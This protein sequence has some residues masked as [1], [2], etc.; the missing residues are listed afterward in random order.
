M[1]ALNHGWRSEVFEMTTMKRGLLTLVALTTALIVTGCGSLM[2]SLSGQTNPP[3]AAAAQAGAQMANPYDQ[4]LMA[5]GG[6]LVMLRRAARAVA[7]QSF[8]C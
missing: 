4:P 8:G 1:D 5:T 3:P 2:Q 6:D 7:A